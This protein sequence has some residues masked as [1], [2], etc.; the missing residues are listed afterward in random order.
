[1]HRLGLDKKQHISAA[2]L[3]DYDEIGGEVF[4]QTRIVSI[5]IPENITTIGSKCVQLLRGTKKEYR[6][7]FLECKI[8]N[9][10][11]ADT[12]VCAGEIT[13]SDKIDISEMCRIYSNAPKYTV[14]LCV[15]KTIERFVS[16]VHR[17]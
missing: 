8:C 14:P 1:M 17:I 11:N 13:V 2:D 3:Q 4:A 5:E 6:K 16:F 12:K 10:E 15:Y 9:S 7:V